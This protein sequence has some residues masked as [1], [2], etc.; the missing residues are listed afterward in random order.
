[1]GLLET[2]NNLTAIQAGQTQDTLNQQE[3]QFTDEVERGAWA[4]LFVS[5]ERSFY[6]IMDLGLTSV[7][8]LSSFA[9][10]DEDARK[11]T[12]AGWIGK[13]AG[14]SAQI[15]SGR[16]ADPSL[17]PETDPE[18][19]D[20]F[21]EL[22]GATVPY[23]AAAAAAAGAGFVVGGPVGASG[24][25]AKTF[26][27]L[28][29]FGI[30]REEAFRDAVDSGAT[31]D[32][33]NMEANIVGG[34]N[35]LIEMAQIGGIMR[36]TK[37]GTVLL[38]SITTNARNKAW[39]KAL[40]AGGKLT[41]SMVRNAAEEA[42]EEAL[43]GTTSEIVP[44][45]LRGK[46]IEPGFAGRRAREAVGGALI[47]GLFSGIGQMATLAKDSYIPAR[48]EI[49]DFTLGEEEIT[50]PISDVPTEAEF[51]E[52]VP[53][54]AIQSQAQ[55]ADAIIEGQEIEPVSEPLVE[56]DTRTDG[57]KAVEKLNTALET[58]VIEETRRLTEIE[59]TQELGERAGRAEAAKAKA[60]EEG[61]TAG[62]A[63]LEA[64][65][66]LAG[67]L[68]EAVF[69]KFEV[70]EVS[71]QEF[72][73]IR[74]EVYNS[75]L[76]T[77]EQIRATEALN[78]L[79]DG[80]VPTPSELEILGE[81]IGHEQ[82]A[83]LSEAGKTRAQK[84]AK[85]IFDV[86][87]LP[88]TL[89]ATW[90]VSMMGRQGLTTLFKWPK[91]WVNAM[92]A[93]YKAFF[94]EEWHDLADKDMRTREGYELGRRSGLQMSDSGPHARLD[95]RED[96]FASE[97]AKKIPVF[98]A[99]IS[100]SER[101]AVTGMNKL[102]TA[103]FDGV[104]QEW[105]GQNRTDQDYE[106]LARVVNMSTGRGNITNK[107]IQAMLPILNAVFFSPRYVASRFE[108]MGATGKALVDLATGKATPA[109]KILVSEA[110]NF[111]AAG[112]LAVT[113]ASVLGADVE[114]DPR[115]SD[116]GKIKMGRVRTDIWAGFQQPIRAMVQMIPYFGGKGKAVTTGELFTK[117]RL[118]TVGRF[119]QSKLNP[120]TGAVIEQLSGKD[121]LGRPLPQFRDSQER[122]KYM[123]AKIT[124]L[125]IQDFIEAEKTHGIK[126]AFGVGIA[127]FHGIGMQTFER[128]PLDDLTQMRDQYSVQIFQQKWD[129]L[130]PDAQ[131]ALREYKPQ[132]RQQELVAKFE[133]RNAAF[134][135]TKQREAGARIE[136]SLPRD[137]LAAMEAVNV[138]V[139]GLSRTIARNWRLNA[140]LYKKYEKD[141][142][143]LLNDILPQIV[144]DP[145]WV[146]TPPELQ[147]EILSELI[148]EIKS[149]VR[150]QIV[151][152][153]NM[154]DLEDIR[155]G[156]EQ[157]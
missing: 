125:V 76:R 49:E 26:A 90:D 9:L 57:E 107:K 54:G 130:G 115:S 4:N 11:V 157:E 126:S 95:S 139:G 14:R 149:A 36:Q 142:G 78:K 98:G 93:S 23:T 38:K 119:I 137:M 19:M 152:D 86:L 103:I 2:V 68:P 43:Q 150:K 110:F 113:I 153:A 156:V 1:M 45:L 10:E 75:K 123:L 65:K 30:M 79:Q 53:E 127:A 72:E 131:D 105:E 62:E 39:T 155:R 108:M 60:I 111:V 82:V 132:I 138:T 35:A 94:S 7:R 48:K 102:R 77:F 21:S 64:K 141:V 145:R 20:K 104:A 129:D 128:T 88:T 83:A 134:D 144:N 118:E 117:S 148:T 89:L 34:I 101:A 8:K 28:T 70:N 15:F 147:Q 112:L 109:G 81:V 67:E 92:G 69:P 29:A 136:K 96:N 22:I 13:S 91:Q 124:P 151:L 97:W 140:T 106:E 12:G 51:D 143:N 58:R 44:K 59:R 52:T 71:A 32:E 100:A 73:D 74:M 3:G 24:A 146:N 46:E 61:F 87:N 41:M 37:T 85:G 6:N 17:R 63:Q 120:A 18:T 84:I 42:L 154:G 33:A 133:R 56:E 66:A 99:L 122:N 40:K 31:E 55:V 16:A 135:A 47:G 5:M 121:F 50:E 27:A 114:E 80:I 25:F 116:F